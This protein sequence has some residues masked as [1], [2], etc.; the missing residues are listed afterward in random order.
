MCGITGIIRKQEPIFEEEIKSLVSNIKHRGPNGTGYY[1]KDNFAIGHSRLS[2]IDLKGGAQPMFSKDR[3]IF[4]TFNGE[5]YNYRELKKNLIL[6]GYYFQTNS[7]TEVIINAYLHWGKECVLKFRGMF[8]FCIVDINQKIFF[9][10]RDSFGIK[11]LIYR[12][13]DKYFSFCSEIPPLLKIKG[14]KPAGKISSL[15]NFLRHQYIPDPDTIYDEVFKLEPGNYM[16]VSM[17][18]EILSIVQYWSPGFE[19]QENK[20]FTGSIEDEIMN[21][22]K[23]HLVSD[24]PFGVLLSGG[25][26]STLISMMMSK[27]M[28]KEL[29]SFSI[30]FKQKEYDESFYSQLVASKLGIQNIKKIVDDKSIELLP[31]IILNHIGEPFGDDSILPT[32]IL[33]ELARDHVP[34]VLSGDGGDET[35]AGYQSYKKWHNNHPLIYGK[36][37]FKSSKIRQIPRYFMGTSMKYLKN[38]FNFNFLDEWI[39]QQL[40]WDNS[41]RKKLWNPEFQYLINIKNKSILKNHRDAMSFDRVSYAQYLDIKTYM[42]SSVL[43]K[44]DISSMKNGLEVRTPLIDNELAKCFLNINNKEKYSSKSDFEGK[45]AFK[46]LVEKMFGREFTYRSKMGF[47][48]PLTNWFTKNAYAFDYLNQLILNNNNRLKEFFSI[49]YIEEILKSHS[50]LNDNSKLLWQILVFGIWLEGNK[51]ITFK[52]KI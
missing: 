4:L 11:P 33:M 22:V 37:L 1:F 49:K 41:Q 39:G 44:V 35:F 29:L 26:D 48:S 28:G 20:R 34:M 14:E 46:K 8:A 25:V 32:T 31:E 45:I 52:T 27:I 5:I 47:A 38:N 12:L 36:K 7:D 21:S 3:K 43:K 2:I 9:L 18:G 40:I 23:S 10:A 16:T 19:T 17:E 13:N 24:V 50:K 15:E 42:N 6:K 30:G 51:D